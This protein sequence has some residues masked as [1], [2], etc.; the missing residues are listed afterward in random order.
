[1]C[2]K[3]EPQHVAVSWV[4]KL[5]QVAYTGVGYKMSLPMRGWILTLALLAVFPASADVYRVAKHA[6]VD[7][8]AAGSVTWVELLNEP[9]PHIAAAMRKEIAGWQFEPARR[10]GEAVTSRTHV[11]DRLNAREAEDGSFVLELA[12]VSNGPRLVTRKAL[13]SA[14]CRVAWH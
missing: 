13:H 4:P 5:V 10:A 12:N 3:C 1:M 6:T 8:D 2:S 9:P 11:G 7:V 14:A